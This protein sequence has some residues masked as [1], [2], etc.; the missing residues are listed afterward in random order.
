MVRHRIQASRKDRKQR[1]RF[2]QQFIH[3][4]LESANALGV[5]ERYVGQIGSFGLHQPEL[6]PHALRRNAVTVPGATHGNDGCVHE[7]IHIVE[8]LQKICAVPAIE[9][10]HPRVGRKGQITKHK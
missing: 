4:D 8:R 10:T 5:H 2:F 3:V 7:P 6:L 9:A 1:R